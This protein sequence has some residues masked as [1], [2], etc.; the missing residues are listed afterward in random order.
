MTLIT[1]IGVLLGAL[2]IWI[3]KNLRNYYGEPVLRMWVAILIGLI[4]FIP[5]F[6]IVA[7]MGT[8]LAIFITGVEEDYT[9]AKP[10]KI[11]DF[12]SKPIR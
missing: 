3:L 12:L 11:L 10:N 4:S 7:N 8:L 5:I 2:N 9:W 1:I 6:N